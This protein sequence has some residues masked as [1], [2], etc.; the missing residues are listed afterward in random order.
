MPR[1]VWPDGAITVAESPEALFVSILGMQIIRFGNDRVFREALSHRAK[2]L[3][4]CS[5]DTGGSVDEFFRRLD[6]VG[7][8]KYTP[9]IEP[10]LRPVVPIESEGGQID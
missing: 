8:F 2:A 3:T 7:F 4:G 9:D 6:S 10:G 1:I 5:V